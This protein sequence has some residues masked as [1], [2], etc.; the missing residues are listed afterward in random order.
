M[1]LSVLRGDDIRPEH[2]VIKYVNDEVTLHVRPDA[3]AMVNDR[4][5]K[6]PVR[7]MQGG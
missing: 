5:A 7:L 3:V 6:R 4:R 2:C 1:F